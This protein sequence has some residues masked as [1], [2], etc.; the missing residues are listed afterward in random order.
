MP[1][2]GQVDTS[3]RDSQGN[4][5]PWKKRNREASN[6]WRRARRALGLEMKPTSDQ[7]QKWQGNHKLKHPRGQKSRYLKHKYGIDI[8][9][10]DS[11]M[12]SQGHACAIC[13]RAFC[14]ELIPYVDH[15]HVEGG[16]V[17]GI[18]CLQCNTGL[19]NFKDSKDLPIAAI[20]YLEI[21]NVEENGNSPLE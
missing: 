15:E 7:T 11:I 17:R 2:K 16:Q 10:F 13:K 20:S 21:T 8:V 18:L 5:I 6:A 12:E 9:R 14:P 4:K 3:I 19:G 1:S